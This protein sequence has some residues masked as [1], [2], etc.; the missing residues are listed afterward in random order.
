MES[1]TLYRKLQQHLDRMPI[2]FPATESGVEI[3]ILKQLFTPAEAVIALELSAIPELAAKIHRRLKSLMGLEDLTRTLDGMADKGLILRLPSAGGM[4]YGKMIYAIGIFE[5]QLKRLTPQLAGDT[6]RYMLEAFGEAF[7]RKQTTQ[8]RIVP[9]NRQIAVERSVATYDDIRAYV[10]ASSGPFAKMGCICRHGKELLGEKC[11]QTSVRE[12]CLTMGHAAKFLADRG[13]AKLIAREEM[14][15]LLDQAD[16]DGLVLQPE[17]TK[18]PMFVCCCCGCCCG[19]L[20]SAKRLPRPADYFSS[21]FRAV[22]DESACQ[23]CGTCEVRCQ[24]DAISSPEGKAQ[25]DEARCIG[26]ALCI[27][28]CPSEA[29]RLEAKEVRKEPP[30]D[31]KALFLKLLQE[32]YGPWGMAKLGARKALG[33]KF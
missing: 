7:H 26:C 3:R 11:R 22:L 13:D 8:M 28:T 12:N 31:S 17:N 2:G 30:D 19:V 18:N 23:S 5:R 10:N 4:R 20:G 16:K 1:E 25:V 21:S 33:M 15:E 14:Q 24:M 9:V 27:P 6:D 32:R 29:L